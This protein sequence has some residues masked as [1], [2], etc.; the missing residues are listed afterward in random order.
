[1]HWRHT[2]AGSLSLSFSVSLRTY[3]GSTRTPDSI[4]WRRSKEV[5]LLT[6]RRRVTQVQDLLNRP[7]VEGL[8]ENY[9]ELLLK[10]AVDQVT[11]AEIR[12]KDGT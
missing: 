12:L 6:A 9:T 11:S 2:R 1:M 10:S 7:Q 5:C 8:D 4:L 3:H